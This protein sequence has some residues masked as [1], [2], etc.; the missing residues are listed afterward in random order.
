MLDIIVPHYNEPWSVGRKFFDMLA[1]QRDVD[2]SAMRLILVNDGPE[3]ALP[4]EYFTDRPYDVEQVSILHAGVSAARNAG[5]HLATGEWVMFCDF[6]DMFAHVYALRDIMMQLPAPDYD[7]LWGDMLVED[8]REPGNTQIYRRGEIDSV[9]THAKLYRRQFLIDHGCRFNTNLAFN[10]D[11]EFNAILFAI[12]DHRRVGHIKTQMPLYIWCWR[13]D[14]TTNRGDRREEALLC[15]YIR[16]KNV[17]DVYE[18]ELPRNR[19]CAMVAR[20]VWDAYY[21]LN[22]TERSAMMDDME[23]DFAF[24]YKAHEKAFREVD[25]HDVPKIKEIACYEYKR[26]NH[27]EDVTIVEWLNGLKRMTEQ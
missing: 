2:F 19:Y 1:L 3:H 22:T 5:L 23:R 6:D 15:H 18:R 24:W 14:S 26:R 16:N 25:I 10:E 7:V 27:R 17:C 12:V 13:P 21:M 9:F 11:S 4:D 8:G 20:T